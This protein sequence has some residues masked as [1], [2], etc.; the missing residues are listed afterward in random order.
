MDREERLVFVRRLPTKPLVLRAVFLV[1]FCFD[2]VLCEHLAYDQ[3]RAPGTFSGITDSPAT[4]HQRRRMHRIT[5][6]VE[7]FAARQ[8]HL[9]LP[10]LAQTTNDFRPGCSSRRLR[11]S[12]SCHNRQ[13]ISPSSALPYTPLF[14]AANGF[15]YLRR[16]GLPQQ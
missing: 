5:I 13:T 2:T 6:T 9:M 8:K 14:L 3:S 7:P 15:I 1:P 11:P 12:K 4:S 16:A 10:D